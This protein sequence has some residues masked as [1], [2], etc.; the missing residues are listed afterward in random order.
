M[1][2]QTPGIVTDL[3]FL[4]RQLASSWYMSEPQGCCIAILQV[5]IPITVTEIIAKTTWE[6]RFFSFKSAEMSRN[7]RSLSEAMASYRPC[8]GVIGPAMGHMASYRPCHGPLGQ[9]S[10]LPWGTWPVIVSPW[11]IWPVVGPATGHLATYQTCHG[12][13]NQLS[14][15]PMAIWPD[16]GP[17]NGHLAR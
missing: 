16:I 12:P 11:A 6:Q 10:A 2:G 17:A 9:L 8:H 1:L 13:L 5:S 3:G 7:R 14:A 15:L 4:T